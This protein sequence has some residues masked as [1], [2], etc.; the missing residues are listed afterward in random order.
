[1]TD[2]PSDSANLKSEISNLKSAVGAVILAHNYQVP[3][4]YDVADFLGDSL[5][6]ARHARRAGARLIVFCGVRFMAETAKLVNPEARVVL[7][8][9][10][11]GCEMADMISAGALAERKRELG[12]VTTVAYVN[13]P[14]AVKAESDICCT[15]ANAV[16]VVNA[17]PKD[18]RIL[19]VPDRHLAAYVARETNRPL[20]DLQLAAH[21]SRLPT[22]GIV[23]WEG[24]CYV[25]ASLRADDVE[26]ARREHPGA[27]VIVHP[28]CPLETIDAADATASTSGMVRLAREHD[29]IVLGTEAGMC[30]RI[31][32]DLPQVKCWPLRRTALCRNMKL[33]RLEDVQAALKGEVPDI[34]IPGDVAVGARRALDRMMQIPGP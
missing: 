29:E 17:Q 2:P 22:A 28:E 11:A 31:R 23:P 7:A 24:F 16:R 1:M 34:T 5:E 15:S 14:A 3:A 20:L 21:D 18:R 9:P 33:T 10:N 6:L 8:A 26:R 12:D 13:T 25:H 32:H 30:D 19:F 27:F 4:I